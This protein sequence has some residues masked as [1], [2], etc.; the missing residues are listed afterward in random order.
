MEAL[1][2]VVWPM[3]EF[4]ADDALATAAAR[5]ATAGRRARLDLHPGQGPGPVR[6]G[7]AGRDARPA[8][9]PHVDEAG[10]VA[11]W[12]VG[13]PRSRTTWPW[14]ATRPTASRACPAGA[15][16]P[17]PP[18]W[19]ASS[20]SRDPRER[21]GVAR[22]RPF[23]A[24][25]NATLGRTGRTRCCS[26]AW[27]RSHRRSPA[28]ARSRR[29]C[30]GAGRGAPSSRPVRGAGSAAAGRAP[31]PLA[32]LSRR[33]SR[34]APGRCPRAGALERRARCPT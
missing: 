14:S 3:V 29:S 30:S 5:W 13:R 9:R 11:R 12:G 7:R 28:P 4:E 8:P 6:S 20:I 18:S 32:G 24:T 10:V 2:L 23:P 31:A 33:R 27:P 19:A 21:R 26:G 17:R 15:R 22:R 16:A 25:L 1:G 34:S